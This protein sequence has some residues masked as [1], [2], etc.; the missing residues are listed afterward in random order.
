[1]QEQDKIGFKDMMNSLCTIYGKQPLDK[2]TLRIWFYKLEKFQFNEVTKAFDKYVD[3]SKFMP[4]P[5]DILM[6]VKEKPVQYNSLPAPK[7]SLDQNRLYSANVMKY[8][9][10]HKPIEQKNLKDMRAWA[11]RII[12][13]PKNYPAISLKFAKDAIN[14]K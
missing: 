8:V 3:T 14:S 12:A 13:N 10:D 7:L 11:Y 6:L 9:D 2:D 5:S 4:T 1:M